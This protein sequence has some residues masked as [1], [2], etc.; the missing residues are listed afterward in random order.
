GTSIGVLIKSE[1][2]KPFTTD[3]AQQ[4]AMTKLLNALLSVKEPEHDRLLI[5]VWLINNID[6]FDVAGGNKL[7]VAK[8]IATTLGME[9]KSLWCKELLAKLPLSDMEK[10]QVIL[11]FMNQ[12]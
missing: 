10:S 3:E 8:Q 1:F 11:T 9:G 6:Q 4:N 5:A 2:L 12:I 7:E